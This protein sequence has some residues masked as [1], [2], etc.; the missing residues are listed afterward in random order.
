MKK[1]RY[2][3]LLLLL[4]TMAVRAQEPPYLQGVCVNEKGRAVDLVSIR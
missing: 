4:L 2:F 3:L 1:R